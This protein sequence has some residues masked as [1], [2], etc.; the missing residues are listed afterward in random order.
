M[1]EY[2]ASNDAYDSVLYNI[3]GFN[4]DPENS[5]MGVHD[6]MNG[7]GAGT[8][9][10]GIPISWRNRWGATAASYE[11]DRNNSAPRAG[12]QLAAKFS[13]FDSSA[14]TSIMCHSMGNYVFR[15]MA[16]NIEKP[17]NAFNN[18]YMVAADARM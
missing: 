14:L 11:F 10:L 12:R 9:I 3:H 2:I 15:V 18:A 13:A 1:G 5:F 8:K 16:Q 6:F 7:N 4:V 17:N